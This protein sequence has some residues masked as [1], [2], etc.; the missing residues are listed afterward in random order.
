MYSGVKIFEVKKD[1]FVNIG[2]AEEHEFRSESDTGWTK[3]M[4]RL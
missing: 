3:V 4:G 2:G 1:E